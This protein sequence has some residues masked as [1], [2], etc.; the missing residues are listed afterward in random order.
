[1]LYQY[2]TVDAANIFMGMI[3]TESPYYQAAPP[4]PA[5]FTVAA[6][7][8]FP[9]DPEFSYCSPSSQ[10]CG[11][12]WGLRIMNSQHIFIY[13]AGLYS[14]FQKYT[15]D[16]VL[17]ENCQD[18]ITYIEDSGD[19]W[20]YSLITKASVEMISPHGGISVKGIDNKISYC[21]VVMAWLGGAGAPTQVLAF[22]PAGLTMQS[23][24]RL[25]RT[26]T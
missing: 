22:S 5:P 9:S 2:Q 6:S 25:S 20:F 1:V 21:D 11:F 15:Q 16:C 26:E 10:S 13:G 14:W 7:Y 23:L 12:S 17:N 8:A 3:Q 4:A 19:I 24:T 18:R